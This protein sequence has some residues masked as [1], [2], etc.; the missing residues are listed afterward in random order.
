MRVVVTSAA[1]AALVVAA[2]S[3]PAQQRPGQPVV[4]RSVG[5]TGVVF[6]SLSDQPLAGARVHVRGIERTAY[7]DR[8]GRFRIDG[9]PPG[10]QTIVFDHDSLD[11]IGIPPIATRIQVGRTPITVVELGVPSHASLRRRI[12][13]LDVERALS[14]RDTGV[15]FGS[16]RD[17]ETGERLAGAL[18]RISW[19]AVSREGGLTISRPSLDVRTDSA[20]NYY[21]C[22]VPVDLVATAQAFAGRSSTGVTEVLVGPRGIARHDLAVSR[23]TLTG[24][25]DSAGIRRGT[26]TLVVQVRDEQGTPRSARVT[27][28][29]TEA[30]GWTDGQGRATF[31]G[32][33]SGSHMV[34]A[35]AIGFAAAR[36][37]VHLRSGDTA[38]VE[39][40]VRQVTVLDTLRV[41]AASPRV[42]AMLDELEQRLR[43]GGHQVLR[44]EELARRQNV[45][46]IF[47]GF[48]GLRVEGRSTYNFRL[49]AG[50]NCPV[51]VY[52]DGVQSSAE[53][54]QSYRPEQLIAVEYFPRGNQ[55]PI[56]AQSGAACEG[57]A[58]VWTRFL[59]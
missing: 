56:W 21:A 53:V 10:V 48:T 11:A 6:D 13:R 47:Q 35:R 41:T 45:R 32:L 37:M 1:V 49:F 50:I 16:V 8:G 58:L 59:R 23:D 44:Q 52:V 36:R 24:R 33:P 55:A 51:A 3:L 31:G 22:S 5:V 34:M 25:P 19:V 57:V 17:A 38:S 30:D 9:V 27:V 28:D 18:V 15:V 12:C 40:A 7:T 39:L 42:T 4:P 2:G 54:L 14:S 43:L 26:A 46:S 29:D 20:G